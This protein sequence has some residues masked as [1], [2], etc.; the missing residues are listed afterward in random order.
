MTI[1]AVVGALLALP[2]AALWVFCKKEAPLK[3][4]AVTTR[5]RAGLHIMRNQ[6]PDH[7]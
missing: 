5:G 2:V 7:R 3:L 4:Y 6:P 1:A